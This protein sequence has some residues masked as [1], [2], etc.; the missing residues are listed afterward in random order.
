VEPS[1]AESH[2]ALG[3]PGSY[4]LQLFRSLLAI[5]ARGLFT[6]TILSGTY[7][8]AAVVSQIPLIRC[9]LP[10]LPFDHALL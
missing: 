7:N 2:A 10:F 8:S 4:V 9:D 6:S 3:L 5:V 1:V